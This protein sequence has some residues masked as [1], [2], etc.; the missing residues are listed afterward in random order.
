MDIAALL[1][2]FATAVTLGGYV[3]WKVG[4]WLGDLTYRL[5]NDRRNFR[6]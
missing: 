1:G 6:A 4:N 3:S 5:W 2:V